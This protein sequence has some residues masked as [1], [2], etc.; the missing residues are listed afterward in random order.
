[1]KK[2]SPK[3]TNYYFF[4]KAN[5][6]FNYHYFQSSLPFI[7]DFEGASV[8][9]LLYFMVWISKFSSIMF[10]LYEHYFWHINSQLFHYHLLKRLS[11]LHL[12]A[13]DVCQNQFTICVCLFNSGSPFCCVYVSILLSIPHWLMQPYRKPW[14]QVVWIL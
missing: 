2:V 7:M 14:Y 5:S 9:S 12:V 3:S 10:E 8:A 13:L 4:W 11:F 1:M 6:Q